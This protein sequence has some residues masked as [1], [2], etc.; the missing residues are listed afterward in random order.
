MLQNTSFQ[1]IHFFFN[2]KINF[3]SQIC[4]VC[5]IVRHAL[6]VN[7]LVCL[8]FRFPLVKIYITAISHVPFT[9]CFSP[10]AWIIE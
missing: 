10:P 2:F 9:V 8:S 4:P 7:P 1:L 3:L 6:K 5:F